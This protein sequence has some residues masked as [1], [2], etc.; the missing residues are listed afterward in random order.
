[1]SHAAGIGFTGT[2]KDGNG[3]VLEIVQNGA[4]LAGRYFADFAGTG[5]LEPFSLSGFVCRDLISFAVDFSPRGSLA[6]FT[7]Q[8][9][10]PANPAAGFHLVWLLTERGDSDEGPGAILTGSTDFGLA[11]DDWRAIQGD[12]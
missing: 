1:M 3:C 9:I 10:D 4:E 8:A 12:S 11:D 6:A 7:G 2:W 5:R